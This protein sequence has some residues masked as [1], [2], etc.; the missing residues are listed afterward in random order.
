MKVN[1]KIKKAECDSAE[2]LDKSKELE[3]GWLC[4]LLLRV[5]V[6]KIMIKKAL[7][8]SSYG[9]NAWRDHLY[10]VSKITIIKDLKSKTVS[11]YQDNENDERIQI[12]EW[13]KPQIVRRKGGKPNCELE[14]KYWQ[15]I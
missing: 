3:T 9:L 2:I 13:S 1:F 4:A 14:L 7:N 8:D 5:G 11:V 6:S 10:E 15:I 12:G